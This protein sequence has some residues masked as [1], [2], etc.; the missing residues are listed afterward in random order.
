MRQGHHNVFL[1][2]QVFDVDVRGICRNFGTTRIVVLIT[3][4]FQFFTN[5]FHQTVRVGQDEQ[6][7]S[8][9]HQQ[10]FVFIQQFFVLKTGQFLQTQIQNGLCLLL[11]QEVFSIMNTKLRL[12]PF[13]TGCIVTRTCQHC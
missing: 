3:D 11:S 4:R 10:L 9:L 8:D 5:D 2:D 1:I 7:L 13:R 6:Q 12:Q